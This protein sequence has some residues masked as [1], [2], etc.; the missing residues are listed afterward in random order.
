MKPFTHQIGHFVNLIWRDLL[1]TGGDQRRKNRSESSA[2]MSL[3][4]RAGPVEFDWTRGLFFWRAAC[5]SRSVTPEGSPL[6]IIKLWPGSRLA[7]GI[8]VLQVFFRQVKGAYPCIQR[9]QRTSRHS[10]CSMKLRVSSILVKGNP[11]P[12]LPQTRAV[13]RPGYRWRRSPAKVRLACQDSE[14]RNQI[15]LQILKG[16]RQ[17]DVAS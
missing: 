10:I 4:R 15:L 9:Q 5:V 12:L 14:I 16:L 1:R 11:K 2:A 13:L 8:C 6:S 7:T 17:A 3:D